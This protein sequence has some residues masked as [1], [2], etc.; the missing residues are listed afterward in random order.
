MLI[1]TALL[2]DSII[3]NSVCTPAKLPCRRVE[4]GYDNI[5]FLTDL[6]NTIL[7]ETLRLAFRRLSGG[8]S[9]QVVI[10]IISEICL[11]HIHNFIIVHFISQHEIGEKKLNKKKLSLFSK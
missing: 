6:F 9:L 5:F 2:L 10:F 7:F 4:V 11:Q 3:R 8:V 1:S